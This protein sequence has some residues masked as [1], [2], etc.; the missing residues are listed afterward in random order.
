M[1]EHW[2]ATSL[3]LL[4]LLELVDFAARLHLDHLPFLLAS[5]LIFVGSLFPPW[6]Q[7][8]LVIRMKGIEFCTRAGRY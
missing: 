3:L 4:V 2:L 1:P 7:V 5:W 8:S 6:L